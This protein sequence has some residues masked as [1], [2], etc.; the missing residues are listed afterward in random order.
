[1]NI[2]S[3]VTISRSSDELIHIRVKC[4]HSR[5]RFIDV[6]MTPADFALAITGL[7][8]VKA[9]A[10][11]TSLDVVGLQRVTE[12]RVATCPLQA[13]TNREV[14]RA[15]IKANCQ[16]DGWTIEANLSA[17]GDVRS[18]DGDTRLRYHVSKYLPRTT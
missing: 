10:V 8:E 15:W 13:F 3:S 18:V 6:A 7:S 12:S 4:E 14:L 11:V 2:E 16:E 5:A 17:Q 9:P 1:M